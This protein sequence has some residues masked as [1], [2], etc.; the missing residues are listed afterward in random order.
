MDPEDAGE[1]AAELHGQTVGGWGLFQIAAGA[2]L[3]AYVVWA[4]ILMPGFRKVPLRLQVP[5]VPASAK[6]VE[7]VMSLLKGRSGKMVDLGSGDGRIVLEAYNQGL[8][9]A[10]GYEL[11]P[12]L[13]R[14]SSYCA[15]KAGLYGKVSFHREDLWKVNLS[16]CK[17]VTVFLAPSVM[18]PLES[19]LLMELPDEARVVTGRFPLPTWTPSSVAGEGVNQAWAYDIR[20]VRQTQKDKTE[21]SPV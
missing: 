10:V 11:N 16:D 1:M 9:P 17:N 5:Y 6:Q 14:L 8:S 21:G 20:T 4:G 12:W 7:N 19:K 2:G 3:T 13:L 15:W 18:L